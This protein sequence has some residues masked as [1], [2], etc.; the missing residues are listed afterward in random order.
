MSLLFL[1]FSIVSSG[2]CYSVRVAVLSLVGLETFFPYPWGPVTSL[3]S[4]FLNVHVTP[5]PSQ[6]DVGREWGFRLPFPVSPFLEGSPVSVSTLVLSLQY[7]GPNPG[8]GGVA[9]RD[10]FDRGDADRWHPVTVPSYVGSRHTWTREEGVPPR[11][12]ESDWIE[13]RTLYPRIPSP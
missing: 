4:S 13:R 8:V 7:R 9:D 6:I 11:T 5:R 10:R 1:H 12:P 2:L 3:S